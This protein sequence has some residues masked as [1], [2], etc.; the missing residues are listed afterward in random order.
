VFQHGTSFR[1]DP[2]A[3]AL[4]MGAAWIMLCRPLRAGWILAIGLLLGTAC[5]LTIKV[6]LYAPVFAGIAWL[7]W[8]ES[9]R[10]AAALVR[11]AAIGLAAATGFALV[12][13]LHASSLP[14][15]ADSAA[16]A[17]LGQAGGQMFTLF[18]QPYWR[19]H[20][21]GAAI[22][23]VVTLLVLAFP[24][25]LAGSPRPVAEKVALVGLFLPLTTLVFYH[26][27][28]PYYFV[29][30][31]APVCAALAVV[32]ER[33]E[34]RYAQRNI[35]VVLTLLAVAVWAMEKPGV[36][37]AQRQVIAA[38]ETAFPGQP[39]YFDACAMLG[40]LPKANVFMTPV[41]IALYHQGHYP[42]MAATM[43]ERPVPL[44]L[45]N[46]P[47]LE[48]VLATR[49][50][51]PELLAQDV[52][53]LRD[54]YI[55]F[56]GPFWI[57]GREVSEAGAFTLRVPGPYRVEGGDLL[58]DGRVLRAGERVDLARG[59]HSAAPHGSA[60]VRL[61]WAEATLPQAVPPAPPYFVDF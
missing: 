43:A 22:A 27:T 61:V 30:M 24:W 54:S 19:H 50:P 35:A 34:K 14:G 1:F 12:Y 42:A 32:L 2:P 17:T 36:L 46:D 48:R 38:A 55:P 7:R 21:K 49:D 4:L 3:T 56:W 15:P 51:V 8:H 37:T 44:V 39:A 13:F 28:A 11:L 5:V 6:V 52:G 41:G 9:E 59:R 47:I 40:R 31:L 23:P 18:D 53:A 29:F 16:K 60:P 26:N 10:S 45:A 58:L 57:A 20:L 25:V 33:A